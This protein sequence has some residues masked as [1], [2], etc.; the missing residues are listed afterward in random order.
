MGRLVRT[1]FEWSK[2][3][4]LMQDL[5][6]RIWKVVQVRYYSY[7]QHVSLPVSERVA[8]DIIRGAG[9]IVV[10]SLVASGRPQ[11]AR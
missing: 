7:S 5:A 4:R 2:V 3:G 8:R 10:H 6:R 9:A 1:G 11:L